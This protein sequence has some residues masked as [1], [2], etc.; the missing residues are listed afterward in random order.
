MGHF[1]PLGPGR[2]LVG[3]SW[4]DL[5]CSC[6]LFVQIQNLSVGAFWIVSEQGALGIQGVE[7]RDAAD[8]LQHT[9][10]PHSQGLL[11]FPKWKKEARVGSKRFRLPFLGPAACSGPRWG[12]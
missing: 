9:G 11:F 2:V 6:L 10:R 1:S 5:Q 12:S 4:A 8:L 7:A 3:V